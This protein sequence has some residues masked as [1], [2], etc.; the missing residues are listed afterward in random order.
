MFNNPTFLAM[1]ADARAVEHA[2]RAPRV[3]ETPPRSRRL[4][5]VFIRLKLVNFHKQSAV[6]AHESAA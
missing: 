6:T 3:Q 5:P 1:Y 2:V 4:V